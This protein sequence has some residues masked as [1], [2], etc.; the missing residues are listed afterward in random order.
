LFEGTEKEIFYSIYYRG[1][2][3]GDL[4]KAMGESESEIRRQFKSSFDKIR[5]ARG[6]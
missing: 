5:S 4:A 2:S 3:I 6:N 1:K